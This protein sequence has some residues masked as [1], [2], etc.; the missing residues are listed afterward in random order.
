MVIR[1]G[2]R[3]LEEFLDTAERGGRFRASP[4]LA[5]APHWAECQRIAKVTRPDLQLVRM[6]LA[7]LK[8][9]RAKLQGKWTPDYEDSIGRDLPF[10]FSPEDWGDEILRDFSFTARSRGEV[11][12][13]LSECSDAMT[14]LLVDTRDAVDRDVVYAHHSWERAVREA[15]PPGPAGSLSPQ[16]AAAL[17]RLWYTMGSPR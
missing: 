3:E 5:R 14:R 2:Q 1:R 16:V 15:G 4:P 9:A 17:W 11:K 6:N 10:G 8:A 7:A 13:I 12:A